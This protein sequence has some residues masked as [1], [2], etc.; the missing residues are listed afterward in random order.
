MSVWAFGEHLLSLLQRTTQLPLKYKQKVKIQPAQKVKLQRTKIQAGG[1]E[2][3]RE[4]Q[5]SRLTQDHKLQN[6]MLG[7]VLHFY[8][9]EYCS[10]EVS[11]P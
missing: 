9:L 2:V 11:Q 7:A 4:G 1:W 8:C 5:D 10:E 3:G 6:P